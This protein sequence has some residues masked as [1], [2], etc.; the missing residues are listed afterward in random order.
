[1]PNNIYG[2]NKFSTFGDGRQKNNVAPQVANYSPSM[3]Q[4][5][6]AVAPNGQ[7]EKRPP[8]G[9]HQPHPPTNGVNGQPLQTPASHPGRMLLKM[10]ME[11]RRKF[12][13]QLM[14]TRRVSPK[15]ND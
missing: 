3:S 7:M 14:Y 6:R 12:H 15:S 8:P 13:Q 1:M 4:Y 2:N 9:H 10:S 5:K 11:D